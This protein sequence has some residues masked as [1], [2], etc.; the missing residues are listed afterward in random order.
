[1]IKKPNFF[2][3]GAPKCGT[4]SVASWLNDHPNIFISPMKEPNYFN[5][6]AKRFIILDDLE[7]LNLFS[8]AT[9]KHLRVGE[10]ST[11]YLYSKE[12]VRNI[13]D[14]VDEPSNIK[15]IVAIRN[16]IEMVVS[17]HGQRLR[18]GREVVENFEVA[19]RLQKDRSEGKY[20][21][22]LSDA[23]SLMYGEICRLGNQ[24]ELLL[25]VVNRDQIQ[26]V[27]LEDIKENPKREYS[28]IIEFLGFPIDNR[29]NFPIM[30]AAR[31]IP[32]W[33]SRIEL[34]VI[35]IKGKLAIRQEVGFLRWLNRRLFKFKDKKQL[36]DEI[37]G[38]LIKYF[39]D[40]I[41]LL[42]NL[43]GRDFSHWYKSNSG[44]L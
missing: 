23:G 4:T 37:N 6:D 44:D 15:F 33:V 43:I 27:V 2:I 1:M 22:K 25:D 38:E 19:W 14:Y 24:I 20:I 30:N 32:I 28:K 18:G 16:P 7:Y 13:L 41:D 9:E 29:E 34:G 26:F 12:A 5:T 39:K 11:N 10:A 31:S 42:S 8:K 35:W 36:S 21:P 3:L 17:L 40:D